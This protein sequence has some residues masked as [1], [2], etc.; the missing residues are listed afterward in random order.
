MDTRARRFTAWTD[1]TDRASRASRKSTRLLSTEVRQPR[2]TATA[3]R[4]VSE[5]RRSDARTQVA[6][7]GGLP[8]PPSPLLI[9]VPTAGLEPAPACADRL[10]KTAPQPLGY[11]GE[12][13]ILSR[14]ITRMNLLPSPSCASR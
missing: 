5:P 2:V 10:L 7:L 6:H 9:S 12:D 11:V 1:G 4:D 8:G 3:S 13:M 14:R